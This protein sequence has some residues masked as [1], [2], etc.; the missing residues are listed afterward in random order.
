MNDIFKAF[1]RF[2]TYPENPLFT[3]N[4]LNYECGFTCN[5]VFSVYPISNTE[6]LYD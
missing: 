2:I 1:K 4:K 6:F 5:S 3:R